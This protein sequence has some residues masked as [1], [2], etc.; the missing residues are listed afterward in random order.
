MKIIE[1]AEV[2]K[3]TANR[4]LSTKEWVLVNT[5]QRTSITNTTK[6]IY[7]MGRLN[8]PQNVDQS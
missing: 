7:V 3:T 1:V 5:F 8:K 6:I 4:L 2:T